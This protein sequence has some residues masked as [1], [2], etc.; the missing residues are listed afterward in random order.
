MH[1]CVWW[2][3]R[4]AKGTGQ[5]SRHESVT[6]QTVHPLGTGATGAWWQVHLT[7]KQRN[8]NRWNLHG[9][10]QL[11]ASDTGQNSR[12]NSAKLDKIPSAHKISNPTKSITI[13]IDH[14]EPCINCAKKGSCLKTN[15]ETTRIIGS[16]TQS[17]AHGHLTMATLLKSVD[18]RVNRKRLRFHTLIWINYKQ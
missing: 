3:K 15:D 18:W 13:Y 4:P 12:T 14:T 16:Q 5:R 2:W 8:Y 11:I 7:E 1:W 17:W 10:W 6:I 9:L